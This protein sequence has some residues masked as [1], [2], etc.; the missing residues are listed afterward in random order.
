MVAHRRAGKTVACVNELIARATYSKKKAP[1]YAYI[2]PYLK[3]SKKIAWS[4]LK[5]YTEEIRDHHSESELFVRLA[6]NKAEI[7]IY[8]A[9]NPD[10]FR[11]LYFDGVILDEFGDMAPSIFSKV[12]LP[13]LADRKGWAVFI[14]TPKGKNHFFDIFKKAQGNPNW[15][16]F[17][18]K[19]SESGILDAE[20]LAL[21]ASEMSEDEYAQEYECS[22]DAA[23]VGTYYS[24]LI[25]QAE[26][27]GRVDALVEYDPAFPVEVAFDI[28]YTD[29]TALWFWQARPDGLAIIDYE[30]EHGQPLAYYLDLLASKSYQYSKIWVPHDA[31]A[32]SFQTGR[33]VLEQMI[34]RDIP[35][36]L[37]PSLSLQDGIEAVR[38]MLPNCHFNP[39]TSLGIEA[40]RAYRREYDETRR[41][42]KDAPL[43]DWSS[44]G[45][46]AFRYLCLVARQRILPS[47]EAPS[48]R[49][50]V[51]AEDIFLDP[52]FEDRESRLRLNRRRV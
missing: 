17:V 38:V 37:V 52:L 39:R 27:A 30:E 7:Y 19:A 47:I 24:K 26:A 49:V 4:Y 16:T 48:R 25:A 18:L 33:S 3:Q 41:V 43:H 11:G 22:F 1:R 13:T 44:H 34:D 45:S 2:G 15:Y 12:L 20:E 32:K 40:L 50:I 5:E 6:H 23:V 35:V 51:Q 21:Q 36:E 31:K 42:F 9:D 8:G 14:G 10:S 28:G 46:D 29:S